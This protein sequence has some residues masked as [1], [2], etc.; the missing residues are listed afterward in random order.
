[1]SWIQIQF[2]ISKNKQEVLE[3][4]LMACGALS[5][6]YQDAAD[7]PILEPELY[8]TPLWDEL[9]LT[10]LFDASIE[11]K[12]T[13]AQCQRL[14]GAELP[15]HKVEILEDKD[16]VREWMDSYKPLQ[17][18]ERLWICP[19]WHEPIAGDAV[20]IML[21]PGLAF[22]TGTHPTTA[23]CLRRLD[24]LNCQGKTVVDY[25]CGSGILAIAA[26]LLGASSAV[27]IDI[28]PQAISASRENAKR[29]AIGEQQLALYL[30]SQLPKLEQ[31]DIVLANILAGPLIELSQAIMAMLKPGGTLILSGLLSEQEASL[32]AAFDEIEFQAP[33]HDEQWL[34]MQGVKRTSD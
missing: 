9:L 24:A 26:L 13:L 33:M 27:G 7:Q 34:C 2:A 14:F 32:L 4:A 12:Q 22:G 6:T 18:G 20:N 5:L 10:A 1:M 16:W 21:D 31:A 30:P 28:D 19:S 3:S 17:M 8:Q 15:Q 23:M 11:V 25:G 29:N